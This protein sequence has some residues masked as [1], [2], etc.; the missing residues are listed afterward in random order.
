M[1]ETWNSSK[2]QHVI[3]SK[4]NLMCHEK[5]PWKWTD[6]SR[7]EL[8]WNRNRTTP[9]SNEALENHIPPIRFQH[10]GNDRRKKKRLQ[11]T[12]DF[13]EK[14]KFVC[15]CFSST[16]DMTHANRFLIGGF[17]IFSIVPRSIDFR[18]CFIFSNFHF[19]VFPPSLIDLPRHCR[20]QSQYTCLI[21]KPFNVVH[22]KGSGWS[23]N[24]DNLNWR[25][26]RNEEEKRTTMKRHEVVLFTARTVIKKN[27]SAEVGAMSI[28]DANVLSLTIWMI[29]RP[30][31]GKVLFHW[32]VNIVLHFMFHSVFSGLKLKSMFSIGHPELKLFTRLREINEEEGKE[33][34]NVPPPVRLFG[35]RHAAFN[36]FVQEQK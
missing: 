5:H 10:I 17:K 26:T 27:E 28:N 34:P 30:T 35:S 18:S 21:R 4:T 11:H 15:L 23:S 8:I 14:C 22:V 36:N 20:E 3:R 25:R 9:I 1:D 32:Q 2:K 6:S 31:G 24:F 19:F 13:K 29:A 7:L 12:S 33:A 16:S